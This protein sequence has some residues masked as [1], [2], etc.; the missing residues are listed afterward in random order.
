MHIVGNHFNSIVGDI[1]LNHRFLSFKVRISTTF[2]RPFS[3]EA[4][5]PQKTILDLLHITCPHLNIPLL[6]LFSYFNKI[7]DFVDKAD[8]QH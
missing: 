4:E 1:S 7:E 3:V 2:S 6:S 5:V 8:T